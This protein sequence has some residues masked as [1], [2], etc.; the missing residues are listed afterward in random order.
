MDAARDLN[1]QLG[2]AGGQRGST[3]SQASS[4]VKRILLIE[5]DE[6][7]C[8][9][10]AEY[11][12]R[13]GYHVDA[14]SDA[15]SLRGSMDELPF[16]LILLDLMIPGDDGIELT[17][18]LRARSNIPIIM[19][20]GKA[21]VVDRVVGLEIGADDYIAKPFDFRELRARIRAVSRRQD[22]AQKPSEAKAGTHV[23]WEFEDWRLDTLNRSLQ[24][25]DGSYVELTTGEYM[26]LETFLRSPGRIRTRESLLQAVYNRKWTPFDRSID[27]LIARL[28]KKLGDRSHGPMLIQ[29]VRG[30]GYM[31]AANVKQ[32]DDAAQS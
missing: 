26:L 22:N 24:A 23:I 18:E 2:Q 1:K 30:G 7:L 8:N 11:L 15:D 21:D 16:D 31:L 12:S 10:L 3:P 32:H 4:D 17:R 25:P 28:R 5:D 27:N 6:D 14:Y 9:E 13:H 29:T 19:I 20:T